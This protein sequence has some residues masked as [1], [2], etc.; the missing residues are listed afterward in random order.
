MFLY[1]TV[2]GTHAVTIT[3][4]G[5]PIDWAGVLPIVTDAEE[6]DPTN[7]TDIVRCYVTDD[8]INLYFRMDLVAGPDETA[9]GYFVFIDTDQSAST[10]GSGAG[11]IGIDYYIRCYEI[12][13]MSAALYRWN[14]TTYEV[15]GSSPYDVNHELHLL[16]WSA[17]LT[18]MSISAGQSIDLVFRA[19]WATDFAPDSGHVTYRTKLPEPVGGEVISENSLALLAPWI[20][21]FSIVAMTVGTIVLSKRKIFLH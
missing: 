7:T 12:G 6:D 9:Q 1:C 4:D 11:D 5:N 10:G 2:P 3:V 21:F 18:D 14:G 8:M 17:P 16:E 20:V 13:P 15:I 19:G